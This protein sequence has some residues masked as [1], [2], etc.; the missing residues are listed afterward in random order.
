M[1]LATH[2]ADTSAF[3]R[4]PLNPAIEARLANLMSRALLAT[5]AMLDLEALYSAQSKDD[6]NQI[7]SYRTSVLEYVETNDEHL[8]RALEV[9]HQLAKLGQHR[10]VKLPDLVIAAVAE[11]EGLTLLHYDHDFDLIAALTNQSTE[12]VMPQGSL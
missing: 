11:S 1:A 12:W 4:I 6:Y 2:I 8:Q 5:C 7:L 3:S 9:Q 10:A